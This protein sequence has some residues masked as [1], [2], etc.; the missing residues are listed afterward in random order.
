MSF[1]IK[2]IGNQNY[3]DTSLALLFGQLKMKTLQTAKGAN[4]ISEATEFNFVLQI[5]RIFCRMG[6][7]K[8]ITRLII[9][10]FDNSAFVL[11]VVIL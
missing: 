4:E 5:A 7:F 10:L 6:A 2:L 3:D 9:R 11:K 1:P 8:L